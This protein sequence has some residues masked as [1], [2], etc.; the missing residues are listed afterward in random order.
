[1]VHLELLD[2][3][4]QIRV[5]VAGRPAKAGDVGHQVY[6]RISGFARGEGSQSAGTEHVERYVRGP[7]RSLGSTYEGIIRFS[8]S[9]G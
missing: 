9:H 3:R 6:Q 5:R 1:M 4:H 8:R 2:L 7:T